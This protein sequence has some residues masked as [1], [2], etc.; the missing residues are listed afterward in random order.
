MQ[1]YLNW[2]SRDKRHGKEIL[3]AATEIAGVAE[4]AGQLGI[5]HLI[6]WPLQND[7]RSWRSK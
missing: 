3:A 7:D 1:N 2:E 5:E 4:A 6:Y